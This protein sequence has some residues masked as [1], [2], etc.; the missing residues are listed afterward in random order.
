MVAPRWRKIGRDL[1]G[2]KARTILVVLAIAIGVL[3]FGGVFTARAVL[4]DDFAAAYDATQPA[5]ILITGPSF[6]DDLILALRGLPQVVDAEGRVFYP[7]E[8]YTVDGQRYDLTLYMIP[9]Y[10]N[11]QVD[12]LIFQGDAGPPGRRELLIERQSAKVVEIEVGQALTIEV[13]G[14]ETFDLAAAG[15]VHDFNADPATDV[16][17][18][19]FGYVSKETLQWMGYPLTYT[20][21]HIRVE[22]PSGSEDDLQQSLRELESRV[23]DFGYT[24]TSAAVVTPDRHW[25]ADM[26]QA[27]TV[28]MGGIGVFT[29][30]LSALL[31]INTFSAL[32]LQQQRQIGMMKAVGA[33]GIDVA[34]VYLGM[35]LVLGILALA[36]AVPAGAGLAWVLINIL[37]GGLLNLDILNFHVPIGVLALQV[38]AGLALPLAAALIPIMRGT[39]LSVR[40]AVTDY[41]IRSTGRVSTRRSF[42]R[43]PRPALLS[44]RNTFRRRGRLVLTLLT[45]TLAGA[46]FCAV[47]HSRSSMV[48]VVDGIFRMFEYDV[49]LNLTEAYPISRVTRQAERVPEVMAVEGWIS[50]EVRPL[51][52]DGSQGESFL[53]MGVPPDSQFMSPVML[54][55]RWLEPGEKDS[56]VIGRDLLRRFPDLQMG[57][58]ITVKYDEKEY[59]WTVVGVVSLYF[60]DIAYVDFDALSEKLGTPGMVSAV[61]IG[62]AGHDDLDQKMAGQELE[63]LYRRSGIMMGGWFTRNQLVGMFVAVVDYVIYFLLVMALLLAV[64]GG[65]GLTGTMSLN[66]LERTREIG[67]M[68]A[69]GAS[70]RAV[71]RVIILEGIVIGLLSG[72]LAWLISIPLGIGLS[73]AVGIAFMDSPIPFSPSLV[74]FPIWLAI[75]TGI[76]V[77]ASLIPASRAARMSVRETL[78]YE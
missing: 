76:S 53:L 29:L 1:W 77:L 13:P 28:I 32:L 24:V 40:E 60:N 68:R 55:G 45:L 59:S 10:E 31:V 15:L 58:L 61:L 74:S 66:V 46:T 67:V 4:L 44:L 36:I 6:D 8:L 3:A 16:N 12:Q 21:L 54:E 64:V 41:G 56:I 71:R 30:V 35:V 18:Y 49:Q 39:R 9:D 72:V 69:V 63:E 7:V 17:P 33:R 2:N 37:A 34:L 23:D 57:D 47:L 62:T 5:N 26:I 48:T 51:L 42:L 75:V 70:N 20:E 11:M 38:I 50:I 73:A 25:A 14:G 19:L 78:E 22:N 65:L 27:M 43:L 52:A